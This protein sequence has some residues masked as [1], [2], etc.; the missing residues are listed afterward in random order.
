DEFVIWAW[1]RPFSWLNPK[2]WACVA[3]REFS[4]LSDLITGAHQ[5]SPVTLKLSDVGR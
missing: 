1:P 3:K 4:S 2:F 5:G